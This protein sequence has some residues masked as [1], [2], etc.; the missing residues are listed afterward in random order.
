[1]NYNER[2]SN[3]EPSRSVTL[4]A[5]AKELQKTDKSIVNL[6]GGEPDFP[7]PEPICQEVVRQLAA[8]NT[9]YSDSRGDEELRLRIARKLQEENNAPYSADQIL[10]TP[11]AKMAV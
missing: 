5:R 4:L 6:T 11:G 2:I 9:H 10:V 1:M 8:G 7:T 3:V